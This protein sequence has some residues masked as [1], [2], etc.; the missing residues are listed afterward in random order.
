MRDGKKRSPEGTNLIRVCSVLESLGSVGFKELK[1]ALGTEMG[2]GT[3]WSTLI[4]ARSRKL[5]TKS[6]ALG[7]KD[8]PAK[9]TVVPGW[10]ATNDK[11]VVA[12][13]E[14]NNWG[15]IEY[16]P[17]IYTGVNSV[18]QLGQKYH[19]QKDINQGDSTGCQA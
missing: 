11:L 6:E 16:K 10:R 4:L 1:Q 14:A 2:D 8:D 9:F 13:R 18:F 19:D 12:I 5:V 17:T 7:T 3:I 15:Q